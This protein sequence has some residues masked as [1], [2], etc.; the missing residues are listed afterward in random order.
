MAA[1]I[2]ITVPDTEQEGTVSIIEKWFKQIGDSIKQY[3]PLLEINTDK[4]SMEIPA[5]E[6]GILAEILKKENEEVHP[7]EI[8]G[9]MELAAEEE[10]T[11]DQAVPGQEK[12]AQLPKKDQTG[13]RLSP[14]VLR[15]IQQNNLDP[16]TISGS[17]RGG[18]IT[19]R[20]VENFLNNTSEKSGSE[21]LGVSGTRMIPHS[22]MRKKI[23]AHMV[24]SMLKTAP[25]VTAVFDADLSAVI[26]HRNQHKD[27]FAK[28][29]V[30]LTY[31]A[32]FL[33]AAVEALKAVPEI[34]S[35]WHED[36]LELFA[37]CNIGIATALDDGLI[38]PVIQKAQHLDLLGIASKLQDLTNRARS[39]TLNP[40]EVQNGTFTITNHGVSGSLIATPIINQPQT[41]ILGVG[42]L[43]KRLIIEE[44]NGVDSIKIKPMIYVT[45]TIDHR[46]LD[47]FKANQFL[48]EFVKT[49]K[50]WK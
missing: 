50:E 46:A 19:I 33:G 39:S 12:V 49:L 14:V 26:K 37:D 36:A 35:R 5:P 9:I 21:S 3:E 8:L 18:R 10:I 44:E 1:L 6:N 15:M 13:M 17:G 45:L 23:A 38:V 48:A 31:T 40:D 43:E 27:E 4:V 30:N 32:Y 34:N 20:D 29:N 24:E 47:G 28:K 42:K 2:D 25:H 41:A 11:T 7:G 22:Q 16:S